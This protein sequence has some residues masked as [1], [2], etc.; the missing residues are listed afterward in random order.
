M[1]K[2]DEEVLHIEALKRLVSKLLK[3][4]EEAEKR[5]PKTYTSYANI[6]KALEITSRISEIINDLDSFIR[7][8]QP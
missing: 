3:E 8:T 7:K 2:H 5:T 6:V 1:F 4:L